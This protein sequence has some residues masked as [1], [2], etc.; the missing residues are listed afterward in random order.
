MGWI[1]TYSGRKVDPLNIK[2]D[3]ISIY[4]IAHALSLKCRYTGHCPW[5]YS[6]AQHS[7]LVAQHCVTGLAHDRLWALLHDS[8]EAYLADL[9]RPVKLALRDMSVLAFDV[10]E[11]NIM[12]AVCEKFSI[13][14]SEPPCVKE[15]DTKLLVTEGACF[16]GHTAA[17]S[18]W[19][20][21]PKN[22]FAIIEPP[23]I[24]KMTWRESEE[25][26]IYSFDRLKAAYD[27][28]K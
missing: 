3:D 27:E 24:P 12:L 16:F 9:A 15:A 13:T 8:A 19:R 28:E 20:F 14:K 1:Q 21:Q 10:A 11:K 5:F 7:V 23:V 6:V 18:E 22:G 26:F 25:A 4:D 2:P 17:Y